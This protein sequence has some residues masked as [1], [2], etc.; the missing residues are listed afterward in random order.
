MQKLAATNNQIIDPVCG[1]TIDPD[2]TD[3]FTVFRGDNYYFCAEGCRIAF[4]NKP[5][6]YLKPKRKGW[7]GRYMDRLAKANEKTFGCAGPKCH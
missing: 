7:L 5:L 2:K 3:L 6:K 4:E 1:M